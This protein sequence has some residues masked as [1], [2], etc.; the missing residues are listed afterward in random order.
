MKNGQKHLQIDMGNTLVTLFQKIE[1]ERMD[2]IPILNKNLRVDSAGFEQHGA[3]YLGVLLTPWFMNLVLVPVEGEDTLLDGLNVGS[4]LFHNLPCGRFEFIVGF[5][6][7]I[8]I[9]MSC[10]IFSPVFEF[11]D[12]DA[13]METAHAVLN[14]VL[15]SKEPENQE[16][17]EDAGMR[18]IW[19][20]RLPEYNTELEGNNSDLPEEDHR[21]NVSTKLSRREL[22]RG[23]LKS[24]VNNAAEHS[25]EH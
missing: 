14:E 22:L 23:S 2:G 24:E 7:E 1:T 6:Q 8:G 10:S 16:E 5:E 20:G 4:K 12:H 11:A 25:H 19:A 3:F 9:Y 18:E 21:E 17:D 13:A 15:T